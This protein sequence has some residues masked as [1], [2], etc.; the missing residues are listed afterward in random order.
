MVLLPWCCKN[1]SLHLV[2]FLLLHVFLLFFLLLFF[3]IAILGGR[4][5]QPP[6]YIRLVIARS[7]GDAVGTLCASAFFVSL[8]CSGWGGGGGGGG[9][10]GGGGGRRRRRRGG[11]GRGGGRHHSPIIAG[12]KPSARGSGSTSTAAALTVYAAAIAGAATAAAAADAGATATEK[13]LRR[14]WGVMVG[15]RSR[16]AF[17]KEKAPPVAPARSLL[18][19][20][21]WG[22]RDGGEWQSQVDGECAWI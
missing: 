21:C 15:H 20:E 2:F 4:T 13:G 6:S 17:V 7:T 18:A 11:G 14:W 10:G 5:R 12:A 16:L 22:G 3:V 9:K 8:R 19:C 1:R